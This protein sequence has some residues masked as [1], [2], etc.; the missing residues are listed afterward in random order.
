MIYNV[1]AISALE[2]RDPVLHTYTHG[3]T[4]TSSPH[5]ILHPVPPQVTR[6]ALC[7]KTG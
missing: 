2:Q 4:Q 1:L 7:A 3:D 6:L 5:V